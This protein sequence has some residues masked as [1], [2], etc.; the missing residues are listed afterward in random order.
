MTVY[1]SLAAL[2]DWKKQVGD[3]Y[4]L[5]IFPPALLY[6]VFLLL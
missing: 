5:R 3:W 4:R 2:E 6:V 1:G